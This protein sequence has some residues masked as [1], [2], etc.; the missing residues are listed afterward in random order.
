MGV[1][2][3]ALIGVQRLFIGQVLET[4]TSVAGGGDASAA[5]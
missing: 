1:A 2:T 5:D 3:V 4:Y